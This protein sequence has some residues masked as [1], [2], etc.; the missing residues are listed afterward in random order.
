MLFGISTIVFYIFI[1]VSYFRSEH[2]YLTKYSMKFG[3]KIRPSLQLSYFHEQGCKKKNKTKQ[4]KTN[5][6]TNKL[7][8]TPL[9]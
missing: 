5:K 7:S 1:L 8:I 6:E 2:A 4:N 3:H 9:S